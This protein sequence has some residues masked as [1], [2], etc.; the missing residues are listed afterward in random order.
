MHLVINFIKD[1]IF[2]FADS[3]LDGKNKQYSNFV[4]ESLS[5]FITYFIS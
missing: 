3:N 5:C 4:S 1:G 2:L